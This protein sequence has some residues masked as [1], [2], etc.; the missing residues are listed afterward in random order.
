[1]AAEM[2]SRFPPMRPLERPKGYARGIDY[3]AQGD[4]ARVIAN[5]YLAYGRK[6]GRYPNLMN[7]LLYS[8]KLNSM[9]L[10]AWMKI[11][12]SGNKLMTD[13]F[14]PSEARS[15]LRTP[16]IIWRSTQAVLPQNES[17]ENGDYFL[18]A[19]HGSG[20]LRR[21]RFPLTQQTRSALES[22]A[23]RW[24]RASYGHPLGEWWYNVFERAIFLER[25]VTR[26][27]PSATILFFTFRGRVR[28]IS[29][30][31]KIMDG[32]G[33]TRVNVLDSSFRFLP[34]QIAGTERV[35]PF[36]LTR[37]T[38]NKLLASAEAVGR[39]HEAVRV[40]FILGDDNEIYL[41]EVTFCNDAGLPFASRERDLLLGRAW[42]NCSF[43]K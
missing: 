27:N 6:S 15:F 8:E 26:R 41:N 11:P 17:I 33:D 30:E 42:G 7:P 28:L 32:S 22:L 9:K 38:K 5:I 20:F 23:S 3:Y 2:Y 24:L 16:E 19:N 35:A 31:E 21:I 18:K 40:D 34:E 37:G 43:L 39:Q 1:M 25:S 29:I 10:L 4:L 14:I 13:S 36:S 12:E